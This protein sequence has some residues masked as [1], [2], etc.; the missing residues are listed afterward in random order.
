MTPSLTDTLC[1]RCGLCCDGTLLADVELAGGEISSLEALGLEVEEDG[2]GRGLLPLPCRA[3]AGTRCSIYPHRPDCCRTFE[4]RLLQEVRRGIVTIDR[5]RKT[6]ADAR[7]QV[8]RIRTLI[9]ALGGRGRLPLKERGLEALARSEELHDDPESRR[10]RGE[11][12]AAMTSLDRLI[13]GAF[14]GRPGSH[15]EVGS[16][17][18]SK[19]RGF[20]TID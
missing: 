15:P 10:T 14:L 18:G 7:G 3:L 20:L 8:R 17:R 6:I 13:R 2:A 11:L 9:T 12:E 5:A 16:R 1:T 19:A 4:C